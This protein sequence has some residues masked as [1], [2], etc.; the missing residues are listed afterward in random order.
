M[1]IFELKKILNAVRREIC[2]ELKRKCF[3][4]SQPFKVH[5]KSRTFNVQ[6]LLSTFVMMVHDG[7]DGNTLI[8]LL[9]CSLPKTN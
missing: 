9:I 8:N 6:I 2:G 5:V 7:Y 1:H 4:G 3:T